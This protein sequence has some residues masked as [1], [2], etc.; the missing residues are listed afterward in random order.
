MTTFYQ[1]SV[2]DP[3]GTLLDTIT[4]FVDTPDGAGL[5]YALSVGKIGALRLTVPASYDMS[6]LVVDGRLGVWRSINGRQPVLDGQ[7]IYLIRKFERRRT[8][9]IV[10]AVHA[11][12]LLRRRIVAYNAGSSYADKAAAAAGDQIKAF[13]RENLGSGIVG[14]SRDG[15][16]TQA[17]I[18]AY[19]T[20]SADLGDGASI[21]VACA[22]ENVFDVV[23][24]ISQA[25]TE[26]G[27]YL[28]AEVV[29]PTTSTLELRTY[30]GQRGADRTVTG[31]QPVILSEESGT[32]T[33]LVLVEDYTGE[34]TFVVAGGSGVG[35]ARLIATA[36]DATRMARSP[37]GRIEVFGDYTNI[38]DAATLQ[39]RADALLRA[40]RPRITMSAS[41]VE[42]DAA[43]RGIHYDLG[44]ILTAQAFGAVY[45]VRLDVIGVTVRGGQATS[46][47]Q[48]RTDL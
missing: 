7:A 22:R 40:G 23:S 31:G 10:T 18:S 43:T 30:A 24:A 32:L 11:T 42:T 19:L 33:D 44:D 39:D 17:D 35:A 21:A 5:E 29:A 13:A 37:F 1:V 26:A 9:T 36:S 25:S 4:Q 45:D 27:T 34:V 12:D 3:F 48:L 16:E 28:T 14:A 38:A 6:K 15:A 20:I 2:A 41:L 8:H 46:R 47:V